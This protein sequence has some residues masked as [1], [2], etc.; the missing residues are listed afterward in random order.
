MHPITH[1]H[2]NIYIH[3]CTS[4][5]YN[6]IQPPSIFIFLRPSKPIYI[7]HTCPYGIYRN[8]IKP[9]HIHSH[10]IDTAPLLFFQEREFMPYTRIINSSIPF[11]KPHAAKTHRK[12][13]QYYNTPSTLHWHTT[14]TPSTS[15]QHTT[16]TTT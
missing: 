10:Y 16:I 12:I 13:D 3:N 1:I 14:N 5:T 2:L 7:L 6:Y 15:H 11:T 9:P 4:H 8:L